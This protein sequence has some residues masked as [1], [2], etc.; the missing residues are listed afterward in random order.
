MKPGLEGQ[1]WVQNILIIQI[2][3]KFYVSDKFQN[4]RK[5]GINEFVVVVD[6]DLNT[7]ELG[8]ME[9]LHNLFDMFIGTWDICT[10]GVTNIFSNASSNNILEF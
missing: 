5:I 4:C 10:C 9:F 1:T 8:Y 7:C 2:T 3:S 6:L